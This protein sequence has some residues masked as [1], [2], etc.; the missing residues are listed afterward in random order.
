MHDNEQVLMVDDV[1]A[2]GGTAQAAC[3]LV[4]A[5]GG[6]VAACVFLMEL[7]FLEGRKK[8][9]G[10]RIHTLLSWAPEGG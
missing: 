7:T 2:T 6:E 5:L 8:L 10:R 3:Y 4:E 9:D 1:L